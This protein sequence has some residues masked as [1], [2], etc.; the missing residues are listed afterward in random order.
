MWNKAL[1]NLQ[2]MMLNRGYVFIKKKGEHHLIYANTDNQKIIVWCYNHDKL[3]IDGIKE[4]INILETE[5]YRHGIII[6]QNLLTSSAKKILDNLFKFYIELFLVKELQYDLT[7]F[8]YYCP[9]EKVSGEEALKI[10]EKFNNSLPFI[11]KTDVISRYF[12]FQ[13]NDVIKIVRKNGNIMYRI[14]K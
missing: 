8:K 9:H 7:K 3:N 11:L 13:K 5:N 12:D 14:V 6:Y 4:F 2:L 1:E 10:K